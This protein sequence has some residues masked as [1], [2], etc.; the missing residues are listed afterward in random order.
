MAEIIPI[1]R[2]LAIARS[3]AQDARP[4]PLFDMPASARRRRGEHVHEFDPVSGWCLHCAQRDD[5]RH[6]G[7]GG[8]IDRAGQSELDLG[9][10]S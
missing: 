4:T 10:D 7:P 8:T 2:D 5:G 6:A 1:R 3:I 9:G